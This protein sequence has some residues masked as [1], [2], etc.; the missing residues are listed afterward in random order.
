MLDKGL[1]IIV[2]Y[3][4]GERFI[5]KCLDS[6]IDSFEQSKKSLNYEIILVIDSM[7]GA[8]AIE[9]S[10]NNHYKLKPLRVFRNAENI[11]VSES[12]NFGLSNVSYKFYTIIDQDDYV[13]QAYFSVIENELEDQIA[14]HVLNGKILQLD[15]NQ[16]APMYTFRPKFKFASL[17]SKRT[18][19]YTP[20]LLIFNSDLIPSKSLFIDTSEN[21]KGCDDWAAYLNIIV[22]L[23]DNVSQKYLPQLLF[24]YCHHSTNY[25]KNLDSMI[26][27]GLAVLDYL[28]N[29]KG[30]DEEMKKGIKN[31]IQLHK[32]YYKKD[33]NK[34]G[35]LKSFIA[36]PNIFLSH[37]IFSF[38]D[39]ER[40]NRLIFRTRYLFSKF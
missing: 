5:F 32:F 6:I 1:S 3:Y 18:I 10:L 17:V 15:T 33:V 36:F 24:V 22:D 12:R 19:F 2:T 8:E 30:V 16:K 13:E 40:L 39:K 9:A 27:S 29:K 38:F 28:N 23:K 26:L 31:S 11:G 7:N 37:Y 35:K 14:V 34:V 25:S 21:Y 4:E 20:G